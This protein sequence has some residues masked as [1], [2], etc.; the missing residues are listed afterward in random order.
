[1]L[2]NS[3][4]D[5]VLLTCRPAVAPQG[6]LGA[7]AS[8]SRTRSD[9]PKVVGRCL[10][11]THILPLHHGEQLRVGRLHRSWPTQGWRLPHVLLM[12]AAQ[13]L[14]GTSGRRP[15]QRLLTSTPLVL[16]LLGPRTWLGTSLISTRRQEAR[17]HLVRRYLNLR[18]QAR[19]CHGG[20]LTRITPLGR[21]AG[22]K[23]TKTCRPCGP[24]SLTS[25]PRYGELSTT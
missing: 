8:P 11:T 19:G 25:I 14:L 9:E 15:P 1:L 13:L 20:Q 10:P 3:R 22:L 17:E 12:L 16:D 21:R 4:I 18:L 2:L 24:A 23:I 6:D 7:P 5:V